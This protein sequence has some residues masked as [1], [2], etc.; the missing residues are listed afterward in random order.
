[1][2]KG[3]IFD[4]DGTL[5][6]LPINYEKIQKNLKI[7][8]NTTDEFLPLIPTI[9]KKTDN[10]KEKRRNAFDMICN[11]E[12]HATQNLLILDGVT[13]LIK[14]LKNMKI[15]LFLVTMQ[16]RKII[17]VVLEKMNLELNS[18]K[19]IL[20]RDESHTRLEQIKTILELNQKN[21]EEVLVIG[22]RIHDI[23]SAEKAGCK[24]I[25]VNRKIDGL[26]NGIICIEKIK[27]LKIENLL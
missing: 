13:E 15:P 11:E 2:I 21:P 1:M 4:L 17:P 24:S 18:F 14:S 25:L 5:I 19:M 20:T 16:C 6:Q 9:V 7:L 22:D 10:D 12:L 27:D 3:I 8:F 23:K 26:E